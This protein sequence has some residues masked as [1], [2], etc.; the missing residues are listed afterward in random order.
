[1]NLYI[2]WFWSVLRAWVF[3]VQM[4]EGLGMPVA[5]Q[6]SVVWTFTVTVMLVGP[7]AMEGGTGEGENICAYCMLG[8]F[9]GQ[10]ANIWNSD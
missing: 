4:T 8:H 9:L 2:F 3:L 5:S 10:R 7:S 6:D 1:M